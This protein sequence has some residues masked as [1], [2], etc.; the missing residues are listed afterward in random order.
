MK[1]AVPALSRGLAVLER[2]AA[3]PEPVGFNALLEEL[4]L[5]RATLARILQV[6]RDEGYVRKDG[7]GRYR[8]G[9]AIERLAGHEGM[10]ERLR[11]AAEPVLELL[12]AETANTAMVFGWDGEAHTA[13]AKKAHPASVSMREVGS[14]SRDLEQPPWGLLCYH[15]MAPEARAAVSMAHPRRH[16]KRY[17]R[18][19]REYV[20]R[21]WSFD[22]AEVLPGTRRFGALVH[23][24]GG[25]VVGLLG[26]AGTIFTIPDERVD[27]CGQCLA[28]QARVLSR[29]LGA[30]EQGGP[31]VSRSKEE[32]R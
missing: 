6:L 20:A 8:T 9:P 25:A 24:P 17:R 16:A 22:D 5:P 10:G 4:G 29:S 7:G 32:S 19:Q 28:A 27:F 11:A 30:P 31:A 12:V 21:G 23:G 14:I 3:Q 1:S 2:I 26:L 15:A 18:W 13:L